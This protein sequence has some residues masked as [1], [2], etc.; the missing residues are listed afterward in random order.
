MLIKL[1]LNKKKLKKKIAHKMI[2]DFLNQK[3]VSK[4]L[5]II[6]NSNYLTT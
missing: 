1:E 4:S 3:E 6:G 2:E 5:L